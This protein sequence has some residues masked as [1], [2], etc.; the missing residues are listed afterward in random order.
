MVNRHEC[1]D[2][3][4]QEQDNGTKPAMQPLSV[5]PES[6]ETIVVGYPIWWGQMPM[7]METFFDTYDLSGTTII[8]F[9]THGGSG[10][11]GTYARI[12]EL[13]PD[14]RV[15]EG[16][17]VPD[18]AFNDSDSLERTLVDLQAWVLGLDF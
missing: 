5:D 11:A 1:L 18:T 6:Y 8:P 7:I 13:E 10:D 2:V 16:F 17:P 14:A 4:K 15:L 12:Q 3:A 9:N